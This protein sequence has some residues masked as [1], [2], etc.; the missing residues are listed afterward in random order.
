MTATKMKSLMRSYIV[1]M[2][3]TLIL[4][5]C[6]SAQAPKKAVTSLSSG[7]DPIYS[8]VDPNAPT[9]HRP[10]GQPDLNGVWT[11]RTTA[12]NDGGG[13]LPSVIDEFGSEK[14]LLP[15]RKGGLYTAEIDGA[16]VNKG[17]RNKPMYKPEYWAKVRDLELHSLKTDPQY[18]C[19]PYGVPR[20]GPPQQIVQQSD[21]LVF[22][23]SGY[24][25][26]GNPYRVIPLNRSHDPGQLEEESYKGDS[27]GHWEGNTLVVDTIGFNDETWLTPKLGYFHDADLHVVERFT[28]HGNKMEYQVTVDDSK[29]LMQPWVWE[30]LTLALNPDPNAK[31]PE[32][33]PC[34]ERDAEDTDVR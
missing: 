5:V 11:I 33:Y 24:P 32:D 13:N 17:D 2:F 25:S 28:R 20:M 6:V 22:L 21:L 34:S 29:V 27:V 14:A 15:S 1:V 19:E 9:P 26:I 30:P 3:S 10:D 18:R 23:Y 16:L 31:L 12:N 4:A 7:R 8:P